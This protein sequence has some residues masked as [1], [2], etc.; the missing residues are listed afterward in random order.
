MLGTFQSWQELQLLELEA[1]AP[2]NQQS[3]I[4]I[5]LMKMFDGPNLWR[6]GGINLNCTLAPCL[7]QDSSSCQPIDPCWELLESS[8]SALLM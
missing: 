1:P 7:L 3:T 2:I 6:I 4:M 8:G 5:P